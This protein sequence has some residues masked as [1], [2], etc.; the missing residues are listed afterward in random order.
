MSFRYVMW[1]I[2]RMGFKGVVNKVAIEILQFIWAG[3]VA[4]FLFISIVIIIGATVQGVQGLSSLFERKTTI[5]VCDNDVSNCYQI[6]E[7]PSDP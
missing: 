1:K 2:E 5:V 6:H 3:I 7:M 4:I